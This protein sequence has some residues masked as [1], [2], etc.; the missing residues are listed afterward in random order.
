MCIRGRGRTHLLIPICMLSFGLLGAMLG[1][2]EETYGL[3]AVFVGIGIA[4]GYD[5]LVGG[6]V[7]YV[8]VA[9]GFAAAITNPFSVGIAQ[10]IAE[11]PINSGIGYR[12]VIF[13]V[14]Q[15]V[16]IWYVMRYAKKVK[17]DPT[18]SV[19]LSLIHI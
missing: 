8:G 9:T 14:F 4:L 2:F 15:S 6:S 11:V 3:V 12:I 16:S 10:G 7:V 19:L 13:I 1:I 5:A 17:A 18:K